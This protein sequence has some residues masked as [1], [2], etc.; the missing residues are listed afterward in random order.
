[1]L[2]LV[3]WFGST[4]N[5]MRLTKLQ[6]RTIKL[7]HHQIS[8]RSVALIVALVVFISIVAILDVSLFLTRNDA[9]PLSDLCT[10]SQ[11]PGGAYAVTLCITNPTDHTT[12]AGETKVSLRAFLIGKS[13]SVHQ[14]MYRL[15][16]EPVPVQAFDD[17]SFLL[18][19]RLF[20]DGRHLLQVFALMADGFVSKPVSMEVTFD[21]GTAQALAP[22]AATDAPTPTDI[23]RPTASVTSSLIPATPTRR[24]LASRAPKVTAGQTATSTPEPTDTPD[25]SSSGDSSGGDDANWGDYGS[26]GQD[27][28]G[29]GS[30]SCFGN[31]DGYVRSNG[32]PVANV[33]V[34]MLDRSNNSTDL[35]PT[36]GEGYYVFPGLEDGNYTITLDVPTG[37]SAAVTTAN[38]TI[39]NCSN[40]TQDFVL[41]AGSASPTSTPTTKTPGVTATATISATAS[42]T[43]TTP[44]VGTPTLATTT[45]TVTPTANQSVTATRT[46]TATQTPS[47]APVSTVTQTPTAARTLKSTKTPTR[48][49]TLAPSPTP[50]STQTTARASATATFIAVA[51]A[52]VSSRNPTTNYGA[53]TSLRLDGS[54]V[55]NAYL[56]FN[57]QGLTGSV[58]SAIL[59]V[60]ANSSSSAGF[61]V[62]SVADN[63]WSETGIN[64]T[65]APAITT[66]ATG[67]AGPAVS[68]MWTSVNVTALVA[69]N[70]RVSFALTTTG[71][72]INLASRESGANAPQLVIVTQ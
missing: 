61:A 9:S 19:T 5:E 12:F 16:D 28:G 52:Y 27:T 45:P 10:Q 11:P 2:D 59:R 20:P 25:V 26:E 70:G 32:A 69:G 41:T 38:V 50:T 48:T 56:K 53:A 51:D 40:P 14:F 36:D 13:V 15:D 24:A 18:E 54:P 58:T 57:V 6:D 60:Y 34:H 65:N 22:A 46:V 30:S 47:R 39:A 1:M 62:S 35:S 49:P 68:G 4:V 72:Q 31:I 37:Y 21:N 66:T 29:D 55:I 17:G 33:W 63:G 71:A 8:T 67:S 3:Q 42:I 23:A 43:S 7:G 64:Y 44:A